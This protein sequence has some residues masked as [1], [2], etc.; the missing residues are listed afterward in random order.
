MP[1]NL[2]AIAQQILSYQTQYILYT[3]LH[4][5]FLP[6]TTSEQESKPEKM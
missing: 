5:N 6:T 1:N 2:F 4:R 3:S